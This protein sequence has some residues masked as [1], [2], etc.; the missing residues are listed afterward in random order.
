MLRSSEDLR[1]ALVETADC[2]RQEGLPP[3]LLAELR[4][5]HGEVDRALI[6]AALL[7][8]LTLLESTD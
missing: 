4:R 6:D 3:E 2:W 7:D 1:G 5:I 8:A